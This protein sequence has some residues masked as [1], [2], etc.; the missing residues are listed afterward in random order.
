MKQ[1]NDT[2]L[3]ELFRSVA[4]LRAQMSEANLPKKV[5]TKVQNRL[6]DVQYAVGEVIADVRSKETSNE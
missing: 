2:T 1:L 6:R 5:N 3:T 4:V